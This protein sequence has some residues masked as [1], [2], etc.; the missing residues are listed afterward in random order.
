MDRQSIYDVEEYRA[1]RFLEE[2]QAELKAGKYRPQVVRRQYIPKA[3]GKKRPLGIPTVRDRVVQM[4]AK[5]VIEPIFEADFLPC[6]YGFRPRR[7][8]TMALE[9]LRK[10]GAKGGHYVLD[11][12]IRD[13]FG[14]ID[15]AKLMKLVGRRISDRRVLK[16][17]WQWL[18]A[19]VME[20]G[21][22]KASV[23]GTTQGSDLSF[24]VQHLPARARRLVDSP[25]RSV[26]NAGAL[27][28]RLRGDLSH[29]EGLRAG[30]GADPSDLAAPRSRATS[31]K[32]QAS[33]ALRWQAG[34]CSISGI[35][36][37]L[38]S[39]QAAE[40]QGA[41]E[42]GRAAL[43]P[44][45]LAVAARDAADPEPCE[46]AHPRSRCHADI[47]DV[48]EQLN[49]VL[50]GWG[51]YFRTGNAAKRFNQLDTYVWKQLQGLLVARKGRH[52][53]PKQVDRWDRDYFHRLGLYQLRGTVRYPEQSRIMEAA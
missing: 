16:L 24:A 38:S 7:S 33:R 17:L 45:S 2:L 6:S 35:G 37:W 30:R 31:G 50:R 25:Q 27:R 53:K 40:R 12:D 21:V 47:R 46:A 5:L 11:A 20:D 52:L 42:V 19:G 39:A 1:Q 3:D 29:Q 4:A 13:Y 26:W 18:E 14:S 9:T 48:I 23:R 15:H 43:L 22:V 10:L 34:L 36:S 28:G 8:A 49:P 51:N 32:D 44:P 41:G